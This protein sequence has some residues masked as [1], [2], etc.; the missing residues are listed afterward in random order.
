M[1]EDHVLNDAKGSMG[2]WRGWILEKRFFGGGG[3]GG[4]GVRGG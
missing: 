2:G 1:M 4:G 3:Q